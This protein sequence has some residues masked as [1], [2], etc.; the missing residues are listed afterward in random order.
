MGDWS[1]NGGGSRVQS[2]DAPRP[3]GPPPLAQHRLIAGLTARLV[4]GYVDALFVSAFFAV[5]ISHPSS[6]WWPAIC[7]AVYVVP[8]TAASG[9]TLG[10]L[11]VGTRVVAARTL[12]PPGL[13]T[14]LVRWAV[15]AGPSLVVDAATHS[16][17]WGFATLATMVVVA[18]ITWD[19]LRRGLHDRAAGTVV[20]RTR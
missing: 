9:R 14:S 19:L 5:S 17:R 2:I 10:K 6:S 3:S 7:W 4:G 15:L 11:A 18:P 16:A 8:S 1:G 13:A 12:R 20:I